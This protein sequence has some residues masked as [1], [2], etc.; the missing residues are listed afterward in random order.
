M[1][2]NKY[3]DHPDS[4]T[5]QSVPTF[6]S[7]NSYS[8]NGS[9]KSNN[10]DFDIPLNSPEYQ[11]V[12]NP[13]NGNIYTNIK[14]ILKSAKSDLPPAPPASIAQVKLSLQR[15]ASTSSSSKSKRSGSNTKKHRSADGGATTASQTS[16]IIESE[17]FQMRS[18]LEKQ[19]SF[20]KE[21]ASRMQSLGMQEIESGRDSTAQTRGNFDFWK[22]AKK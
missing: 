2:E 21:L 6:H 19:I 9:S 17:T 11:T 15:A 7:K 14:P 12:L 22:E 8:V 1:T 16:R 3:P 18:E 4:T 13:K 20:N 10:N 5:E